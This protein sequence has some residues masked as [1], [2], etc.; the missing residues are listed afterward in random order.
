MEQQWRGVRTEEPGS[1]PPGPGI[2]AEV[3]AFIRGLWVAEQRPRKP[4]E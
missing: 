4:G 3:L 2:W 1:G